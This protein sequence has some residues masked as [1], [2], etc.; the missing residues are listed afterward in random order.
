MK[1]LTIAGLLV[2]QSMIDFTQAII[3]GPG[4]CVVSPKV[5]TSYDEVG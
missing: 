3:A 4:G 5:L 1:F 2:I